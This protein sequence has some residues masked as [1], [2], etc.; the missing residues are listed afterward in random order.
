MTSAN[1]LQNKIY[2]VKVEYQ[3]LIKLIMGLY[4]QTNISF[5]TVA[6]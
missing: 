5:H 6:D 2:I 1:W 4:Q 3:N